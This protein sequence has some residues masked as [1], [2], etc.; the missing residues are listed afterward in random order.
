MAGRISGSILSDLTRRVDKDNNNRIETNEGRVKGRVGN[1]NGIAGVQETASSISDGSAVLYGFQLKATDA[2]AVADQLAGGNTW[3]SKDDLN[4]STAARD[5][6]D[7]QGG[8]AR[9]NRISKK[10]MAAALM[11]GGLAFN[12][13]GI[14]LSSEVRIADRPTPPG[15]NSG[16]PTPPPVGGSDRPTP[17]GG[18]SGRPTPPPVGGSDRPTPPGG[19]SGRPT[20]PPVSGGNDRPT[21]P[22]VDPAPPRPHTP[23]YYWMPQWPQLMPTEKREIARIPLPPQPQAGPAPAAARKV[24]PSEIQLDTYQLLAEK[25]RLRSRETRMFFFTVHP[26][27]SAGDAKARQAAGKPVYVGPDS[28]WHGKG[29]YQE[30]TGEKGLDSYSAEA[31][32]Q[33]LNEMQAA[34]DRAYQG[35]VDTWRSNHANAVSNWRNTDISHRQG[36]LPQFNNIYD[37]NR[38]MFN[39]Y[40]VSVGGKEFN[41]NLITA[42]NVYNQPETRKEIARRW[43]EKP[44]MGTAEFNHMANE[45]ISKKISDLGWNAQYQGDWGTYLGTNPVPGLRYPDTDEDV[46]WN[47]RV[48]REVAGEVPM[49]LGGSILDR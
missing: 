10:E 42:T 47:A 13:D 34:E 14:T 7:G 1:E 21:P 25:G 15:G 39:N 35:R 30:V 33:K 20:P 38:L 6:I 2:E 48:I 31:K 49:L 24:D 32:G 45:V 12:R 19:N 29:S 3:I 40:M 4:L 17:P 46:N 26:V 5:Q 44:E 41:R 37:T 16:R 23:R 28:G 27:L 18:N 11:R 36:A 9:D 22:G 43:H 8:G